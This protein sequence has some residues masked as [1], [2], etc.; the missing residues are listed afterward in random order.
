VIHAAID[1]LIDDG[2]PLIHA[3]FALLGSLLL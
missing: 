1:A 2:C 3:A